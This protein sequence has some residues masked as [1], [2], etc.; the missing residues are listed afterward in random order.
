MTTLQTYDNSPLMDG[1]NCVYCASPFDPDGQHV[2][3]PAHPELAFCREECA[4]D[5]LTRES[6]KQSSQPG[7]VGLAF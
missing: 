1:W 3:H 7:Q 4:T 6:R 5:Y 2:T